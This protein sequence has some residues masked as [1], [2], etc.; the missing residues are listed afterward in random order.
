MTKSEQYHYDSIKKLLI[1]SGVAEADAV[2]ASHYAIE[3]SRKNKQA[4]FD[5]LLREAKRYAKHNKATSAPSI[6]REIQPAK[7][8]KIPKWYLGQ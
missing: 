8:P 4:D 1:G 2:S 7:L 6:K 3:Y 5:A